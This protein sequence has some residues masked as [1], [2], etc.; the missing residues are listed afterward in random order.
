MSSLGQAIAIMGLYQPGHPSRARTLDAAYQHL[1][2]LLA[3][4]P[5][6]QLSFVSRE[7]IHGSRTLRD[8]RDWAPGERLAS[9]GIQRLEFSA[10]VSREDFEI[11][12]DELARRLSH[13][14]TADAPQMRQCAIRYGALGLRT[15]E[16]IA[17]LGTALPTATITYTLA[18]EVAAT[19]W[20]HAEVRDGR[21]IPLL[22]AEATVRSL[23]AA[24][25]G[26][27][28]LVLPLLTLREYDEYTTTHSLNVAVLAMA[29]S[30]TLGLGSREVRAFGVAGLLHDIGKVAI[31]TDIL[32][33]PGKLAPPELELIRKHPADGARMIL[34]SGQQLDLAAVVAYEHHIMLDGN[35]YPRFRCQR[36]CHPAS[37]IVHLCD[38]YDAL[39][40]RRPYRDSWEHDAIIAYLQ[41]NAG[42]EFEPTLV[43][44]FAG[45]MH[46][47]RREALPLPDR[48]APPGP[49]R[50]R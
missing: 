45:M 18:E 44:A 39:R 35:G 47:R 16:Q 26:G 9:A 22:E 30:E 28:E 10:A 15:D 8:L 14:T 23:T 37:H 50:S 7:V 13:P 33:K 6:P 4:D 40:T 31:P 25:H 32:N 36:D 11:F 49:L 46:E 24:M 34:Q 43:R 48:A 20:V 5:A 19:E 2:S 38:V 29:L 21:A 27:H 17:P 42:T 3:A 1:Q 12:V 41:A